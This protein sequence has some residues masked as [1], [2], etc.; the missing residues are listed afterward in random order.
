MKW[1]GGEK[2]K[3]LPSFFLR[4]GARYHEA[5]AVVLSK[6]FW[7]NDPPVVIL[8]VSLFKKFE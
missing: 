6:R 8:I 5:G 4:A 3:L 7:S 1:L 2:P